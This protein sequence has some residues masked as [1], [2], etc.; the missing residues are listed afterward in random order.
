M[1]LN[2]PEESLYPVEPNYF[3]S[4]G[5][6]TRSVITGG[7]ALLA[8][9]N[10]L[11]IDFRGRPDGKLWTI[12]EINAAAN[13]WF[14]LTITWNKYDDLIVYIN[15]IERYRVSAVSYTATNA[16]T[17]SVMHLGKPN[18][19]L[20]KFVNFSLDEWFFWGRNLSGEVVGLIYSLYGDKS[21][22]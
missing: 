16:R 5:G 6:Q 21:N 20:D 11:W 3:I 1:W 13:N 15:G 19:A 17:S 8:K 10:G 18:S 14:H 22:F 2:I 12:S 9:N 4:S 7:M